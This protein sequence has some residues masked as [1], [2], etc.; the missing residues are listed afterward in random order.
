MEMRP[1]VRRPRLSEHPDD[2]AKESTISG[3]PAAPLLRI[4]TLTSSLAPCRRQLQV[5]GHAARPDGLTP[6]EPGQRTSSVARRRR[7]SQS[8]PA[9][10]A[11]E[12]PTAAPSGQATAPG[13]APVRRASTSRYASQPQAAT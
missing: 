2:D 13:G 11:S 4:S 12:S 8:G 5:Y 7:A 1:T 10:T 3:I 9:A 6:F